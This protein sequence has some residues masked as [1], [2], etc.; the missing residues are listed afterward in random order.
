MDSDWSTSEK[1]PL[2]GQMSSDVPAQV[3]IAHARCH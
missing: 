2:I 3:V 1:A